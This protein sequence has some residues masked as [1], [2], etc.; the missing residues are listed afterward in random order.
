M[1]C[2]RNQARRIWE[3]EAATVRYITLLYQ[4]QAIKD[5]PACG[6]MIERDGGCR[7]FLCT[8]CG[9]IFCFCYSTINKCKCTTYLN[10]GYPNNT[11]GE[12]VSEEE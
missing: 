9:C 1:T 8:G 5:Y 2:D 10:D 6:T 4:R 3:E 11:T 7:K 12:V